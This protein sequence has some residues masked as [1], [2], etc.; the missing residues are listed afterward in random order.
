MTLAAG[1]VVYDAHGLDG[2]R[3]AEVPALPVP[4]Q[5]T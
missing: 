3:K 2:A 4:E 5:Q 1:A